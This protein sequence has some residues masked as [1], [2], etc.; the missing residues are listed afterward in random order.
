MDLSPDYL[1]TYYAPIKTFDFEPLTYKPIDTGMVSSHLYDPLLKT[2]KIYQNLGIPGQA[3]QSIIFNYKNETGFVYQTLPYPLYFKKQS[4]MILYKPQTTYSKVG[5]T[6]GFPKE[7][8]V[9]AV[10]AKSMKRVTIAANI[11]G[12]AYEGTFVHQTTRKICGDFLLH[13]EVPSSIFGVRAAYI[14]NFFNNF[15]NGGVSDINSYQKRTA[16]SNKEYEVLTSNATSKITTHD[17]ALQTYL[18]LI[19]KK[20]KYFGTFTYDFQFTQTTLMYHDHFDTMKYPYHGTYYSEKVTNDSSRFITFK[21]ALQWSNFSPNQEFKS[22]DYFFYIAGGVLHDYANIKYSD[23]TFNSFDVFARTHIRLFKLLD[24][25]AKFTYSFYGY[26]KNEIA[27]NAEI[28]FAINREKEHAIGGGANFYNNTPE[29]IMQHIATNNFLWDTLFAKQNILQIKAFWNFQKYNLSVSYYYL[30]KFVYLSEELRPVQNQNNGNM[31]QVSGFVP[32]RYK[33]FGT[34]ANLNFQYC[35]KEVVRVP[36]FAG[37]LSVFYIFELLK[38]RLK[39]QVG[40]D[41]MFNTAYYADAY[42][43]VLYRFHYQNSQ[44]VGN[45][46]FMD[47]NL[48]V[49]IDRINFYF[50]IGNLLAPAMGYRNFTT[51]NYPLKEF[52]I[53]LGINWR[54][55]D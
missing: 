48:T 41:L 47:A 4:D 29:Y 12:A 16:V 38:K 28:A 5:Y 40:T 30:N 44:K 24:I 27:A 1:P 42:L 55:F 37:K 50:R 17:F 2:D 32:F 22:K 33:N 15:E 46:L 31:F 11:N 49:R 52:M 8:E 23:T 7:N 19:N 20:K 13:Y 14:V 54:F 9:F 21:N 35:T 39:I 43:P 34:T 36:L 53:H 18:N 26:T 51:P 3:H 6:I 45:F 25:K 10:F